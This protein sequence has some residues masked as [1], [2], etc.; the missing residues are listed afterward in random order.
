MATPKL[1][2][3]SLQNQDGVTVTRASLS[4]SAWLLFAFP[5][6]ATSGCTVQAQ[7]MKAQARYFAARGV[8]VLGLSP[9][10]PEALARWKAKEGFPFDF[11]S[12]PEHK[13]LD[14]LGAWGEKSMYGKK[15]LGVIRSHWFVDEEG[16]IIDAQMKVSPADSVARARAAVAAREGGKR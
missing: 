14:A 4:G 2:A 6:A 11:L 10:P 12:D 5:K 13:L 8:K 16:R 9:D 15:Y 3:F 7:G 1:P